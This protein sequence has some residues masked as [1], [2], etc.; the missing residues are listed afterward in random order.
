[1]NT[2]PSGAPPDFNAAAL[3][4]LIIAAHNMPLTAR[5][6]MAL[7]DAGFR[8]A[9][10]AP[11]GNPVRRLRS[12]RNHFVRRASLPEKSLVRAIEQWS[13]D[14][15]V[16]TDD[17]SIRDLQALHQRLSASDDKA[18]QRISD[19]IELSLGPAADFDTTRNKSVFLTR[20]EA[21]GLRCPRTIVVP[22]AC[23]FT[24]IPAELV[25]PIIVKAD[26]SYG[27][28]CVRWAGSAA[29]VRAAVWELQTPTTWRGIFRRFAGVILG[30]KALTPF[31]LPLRRTIS[32]QQCIEG[33]PSNRAVVCWKGEV[34][35]G[36]S[37]EAVEVL[38]ANGPASVV[39]LIDH[40]EMTSVSAHMVRCLNL[41]G[42]VGFDFI[43]DASDRAWVI[44]MNPRV[45]P[46]CHLTP[47]DGTNLAASL[48][49]QMSG[50]PPLP[51]PASASRDVIALFPSEIIRSQA[52]EHLQS[53]R[54]DVPWSEL[55]LVHCMLDQ[56]LRRSFTKRV[57]N[58]TFKRR[59]QKII[60]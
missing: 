18:D 43:L 17:L 7:A 51:A 46:I 59:D 34:L 53:C 11:P 37:A 30:S 57:H 4:I 9:T 42:F 25:Y 1:M 50:L 38:K 39:R 15:L 27:G 36:I 35:A 13:P 8:I 12:V 23:P 33:R 2:G 28:A 54:H 26:Q 47:A 31:K 19:L 32:L 56:A 24:S 5:I 20:V 60:E 16:C 45:T 58:W 41:S 55:Q 6:S 22:A 48:W 52:S 49:R 21:E 10:L 3:K 40:P 44:E 29:A 14:F